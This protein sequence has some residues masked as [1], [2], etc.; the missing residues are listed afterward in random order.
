MDDLGCRDLAV[1]GAADLK[2]PNIDRIA[3]AGAVF[4]NWYSNIKRGGGGDA[5]S[6]T[7]PEAGTKASAGGAWLP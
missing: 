6:N 7:A 3:R 4:E 2:T 5:S 1:Y